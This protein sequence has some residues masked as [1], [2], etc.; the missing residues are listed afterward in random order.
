METTLSKLTSYLGMKQDGYAMV[1]MVNQGLDLPV[2]AQCMSSVLT[3][4]DWLPALADTAEGGAGHCFHNLSWQA[5][6]LMA[7]SMKA[8]LGSWPVSS[9]KTF[10]KRLAIH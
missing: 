6:P 10:A 8:R 7:D 2:V 5:W 3:E 4:G 1:R 9:Q